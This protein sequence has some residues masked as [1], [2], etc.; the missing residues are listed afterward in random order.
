MVKRGSM[1][2]G[3]AREALRLL[4]QALRRVPEPSRTPGSWPVKW[5]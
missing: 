2:S 3:R 5:R 1:G 4:T